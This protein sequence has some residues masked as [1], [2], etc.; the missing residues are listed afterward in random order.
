[1]K[2]ADD[3]KSVSVAVTD[4]GIGMTPETLTRIF[5]PFNQADTSLDRSRG[6]LGLGLALAKGLVELHGGTIAAESRGLGAGST[7]TL[8]LPCCDAPEANEPAQA[9]PV[10]PTRRV[11]II[12]D[13]RD[14]VLPLRR[15]L[16]RE[17]HVVTAAMDGPGGLEE[18][19]QFRPDVVLCDIGLSGDMNGYEVCRELRASPDV[20]AAYMVAVTGYGQEEDR[21]LAREAGFDFHLT[22]PVSR[23]QL[24]ELLDRMPRF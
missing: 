22:K 17:G 2:V 12:D 7:I 21:R 20:A 13:R 19:R 3:R 9:E 1:M 14:A 24:L 8:A 10:T 4:H 6:G 11:L 16:E 23:E 15:L 18:A 5:E